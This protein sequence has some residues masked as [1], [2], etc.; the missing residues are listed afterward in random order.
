MITGQLPK[1][2]IQ[3]NMQTVH[4]ILKVAKLENQ[5][6]FERYELQDM[7]K[8]AT[9]SELKAFLFTNFK[10]KIRISLTALMHVHGP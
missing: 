5:G 6:K 4:A 2:V 8:F 7:P 10:E 9:V 3:K 1:V